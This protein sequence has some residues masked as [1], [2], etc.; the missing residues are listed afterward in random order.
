MPDWLSPEWAEAAAG[1]S[2]QLPAIEGVGGTVSWSFSLAPRKEVGFKWRY[3]EGR[4]GS[5]SPGSDPD[6]DLVLTL[7]A[8]DAADVIAGRVEPS[9][10]FM[11]GRL[12]AAGDGK[13]LL[14]FLESTASPAYEGWRQRMAE[15]APGA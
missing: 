3:E 1:L 10:A 13:L 14:A 7:S 6:A 12:K 15:L 5:G 8:P 4:P 2:E 11:R 9:V